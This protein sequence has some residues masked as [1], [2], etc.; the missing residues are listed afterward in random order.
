MPSAAYEGDGMDH[1]SDLSDDLLLHI[2]RFLSDDARDV[3]CT[4][5]LSTRWRSLWTRAPVLRIGNWKSRGHH[6]N[7]DD[8]RFSD[9]VHNMLTRRA[10][11]GAEAD[12]DM[13]ELCAY[14]WP[15][16]WRA[17]VWF[18]L[19]MQLTVMSLAFRLSNPQFMMSTD[20][21]PR[22]SLP[23]STRVTTLSLDLEYGTLLLPPAVQF[24]ELTEL[25][26]ST[27]CFSDDD[28][29]RLG[30]PALVLVVLPDAAETDALEPAGLHDL[31]LHGLALE[32]LHLGS[33]EDV[34]RLDV[35]APR[36]SALSVES[37]FMFVSTNLDLV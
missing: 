13:L 27:I 2:L 9:F 10:N 7:L 22:H 1:I 35:D 30:H 19:A 33:L 24:L 11:G 18:G 34:R 15:G 29:P 37:Y 28:G 36:L 26:L 12:I 3:V 31:R 21:G 6:A 25:T 4:T 32:T 14:P 17:E 20:L 23:N 8:P 5:V 16:K